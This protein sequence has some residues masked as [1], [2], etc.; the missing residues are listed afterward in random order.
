MDKDKIKDLKK[1]ALDADMTLSSF[2]AVAGT[3]TPIKTI[4]KTLFKKKEL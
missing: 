1:R 4:K 2:L 3:I